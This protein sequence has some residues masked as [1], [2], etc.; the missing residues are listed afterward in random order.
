M[1]GHTR[2]TYT[3]RH[4]DLVTHLVQA[5]P[6]ASWSDATNDRLMKLFEL[7]EIDWDLTTETI[8]RSFNPANEQM[9]RDIAGL[10]RASIEGPSFVRFLADMQKWDAD[11]DARAIATPTLLIH[12]K[13]QTLTSP[14][15]AGSQH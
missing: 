2:L 4:P 11:A 5:T 14:P 1:G 13:N 12:R 6:A 15:P 10:V 3:A 8:T 7:S 9:A